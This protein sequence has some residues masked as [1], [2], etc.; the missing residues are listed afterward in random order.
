M[1][2]LVI[3]GGGRR[4]KPLF[5]C[6]E[7]VQ[8]ALLAGDGTYRQWNEE[9]RLICVLEGR[10][11]LSIDGEISL[12]R[13]GLVYFVNP[14]R[15]IELST[16]NSPNLV[17]IHAV[18]QLFECQ[19]AEAQ[20]YRPSRSCWLP[21][22]EISVQGPYRVAVLMKE[23][24]AV[25]QQP[26]RASEMRR[27]MVLYELLLLV[28]EQL[29][30]HPAEQ[31][32][33]PSSQEVRVQ[34]VLH[35][36]QQHYS[37]D[38]TRDSMAAMAGFHPRFFSKL[39]KEE[40]GSGFAEALANIRIRAAKEQL[41]LTQNNLN[42]IALSVGYSNGLY[43]SRKFKQLTGFSP[44]DYRSQPKR[45]VIYDWI[46]SLLAL[47]I[48]PVGASYFSG[49]DSLFLL[50]EEIKGI[51]E[52][53]RTTVDAVIALEPE[54]IVVP[55]WL[56]SVMISKLQKIAPTL[57]LPYGDPVERFRHLADTL[58]K[59]A[60]AE[61]FLVRYMQRAQEVREATMHVIQSGETVGVY[62]LSTD[63]IW[64]FSE[65]HGRG[66]YNLYNAMGL[67]PP[68]MVKK[69]VLGRGKVREIKMEELP[70]YA[71]DHMFISYPFTAESKETVERLMSHEIW[72]E[73]EAYRKNRIYFV[74]RRLF[75]S[76][77]VLAMYKQLELQRQLLLEHG[78]D[79]SHPC[80]FVHKSHDLNP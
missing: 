49:L 30:E 75:H 70:A 41:L 44:R 14:E 42:D 64:V 26:V 45:I 59:R 36:M 24:M 43:L 9:Y 35:Y 69:Q 77:D 53:G 39:F 11:Q 28:Q 37:E 4:V 57:V 56:G 80:Q 67:K 66:G 63:T 27:D 55:S 40:I 15:L 32:S 60:E 13:Q 52:V 65:F 17:L 54:L 12:L 25:P 58:D 5:S 1:S 38:I 21:D 73:I 10:G 47:G 20:V 62:G 18:F 72:Q 74:D 23:L 8:T 79:E 61:Q 22:G 46:G 6:T 7:V 71:A 29:E 78:R 19:D 3:Y 2:R 50:H 51:P 76:Q 31:A 34:P 68:V 48:A 33:N 16:S